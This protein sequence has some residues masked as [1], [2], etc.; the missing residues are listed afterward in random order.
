MHA[1]LENTFFAAVF[2]KDHN[3][4]PT[5]GYQTENALSRENALKGMTIWAAIS[6]FE[7]NE[8]GS[9]EVGK[10]ADFIILNQDILNVAEENMLKTKTIYTFINGEKVFGK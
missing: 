9:L 8:K 7:E 4:Y 5:N 10:D 1:S 6:N 2:R 3:N